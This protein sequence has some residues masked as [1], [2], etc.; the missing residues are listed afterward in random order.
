MSNDN[1]N[2]VELSPGFFDLN[3]PNSNNDDIV[4]ISNLIPDKINIENN[5]KNFV[6]EFFTW[7]IFNIPADKHC[8]CDG[9][10]WSRTYVY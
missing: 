9:S 10:G 2:E 1:D 4:E 6:I 7:V 8:G 3:N 5:T